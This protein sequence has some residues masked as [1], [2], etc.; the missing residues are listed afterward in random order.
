MHRYLSPRV[1]TLP[2]AA[3]VLLE[4]RCFPLHMSWT[5]WG[6]ADWFSKHL[7]S[8]VSLFVP[9]QARRTFSARWT[10]ALST[11]F[12]CG[13]FE[14]VLWAGRPLRRRP[15]RWMSE[16]CGACRSCGGPCPCSWDCCARGPG[17]FC[18]ADASLMD[19][20]FLW[21]LFGN[22]FQMAEDQAAQTSGCGRG[23]EWAWACGAVV[24]ES[25]TGVSDWAWM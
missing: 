2:S 21:P 8:P 25:S 6:R 5:E 3:L 1:S 24:S 18:G 23:C 7:W 19:S 10:T 14:G 4:N 17:P 16:S 12:A 15:W 13:L 22:V 20:A 9:F 11:V